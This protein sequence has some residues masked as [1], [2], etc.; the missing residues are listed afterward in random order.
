MIGSKHSYRLYI[1]MCGILARLGS[2][3]T[4]ITSFLNRLNARGPE[5]M[6]IEEICDT[7]T[8]GFTRLAI[9][10]LSESGMQ[11]F[12]KGPLT[13]ICNGEIY[14]F[15][16][17]EAE[18]G[19]KTSGSSDCACIGDLYLKYRDS[20]ATF[21]RAL[22][23]VFSLVIYD[24]ERNQLF[25]ARDP[26]GIRPLFIASKPNFHTMGY[27]SHMFI[28]EIKA[29]SPYFD[30][31]VPFFPGYF[32]MYDTH[33]CMLINSQQYKSMNFKQK[34]EAHR[35]LLHSFT[36]AHSTYHKMNIVVDFN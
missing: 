17:L 27:S 35:K 28:S 9:N 21:L 25:V 33:S 22:D 2:K 23:G 24:D 19:W 13:W 32:N 36:T 30:I 26:Y 3:Q 11:P 31:I 16:Q 8:M 12:T 6:R 15:K 10:G 14:N 34:E 7:V 5:Q 29:A 1:K 18:L 20:P 4:P